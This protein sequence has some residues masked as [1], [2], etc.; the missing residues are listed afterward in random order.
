[1]VPHVIEVPVCPDS[2]GTP[3]LPCGI[4]RSGTSRRHWRSPGIR[5]RSRPAERTSS[6]AVDIRRREPVRHALPGQERPV[7][8][9]WS[10][11]DVERVDRRLRQ[12]GG[13]FLREERR[14]GD[15]RVEPSIA[16]CCSISDPPQTQKRLGLPADRL[17][18]GVE[19]QSDKRPKSGRRRD[20]QSGEHQ[21]LPDQNAELVAEVVELARLVI[22]GARRCGRMSAVG[23]GG[24]QGGSF[25]IAFGDR[26]HTT[27]RDEESTPVD[28]RLEAVA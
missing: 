6:T 12:L 15:G 16:A 19:L 24:L 20:N 26:V 10:R 8:T 25:L 11:R 13:D 17:E 27:P 3:V 1:M 7:R 5:R 2:R 23:A 22:H 28:A 14:T 9:A 21:V 4:V 18:E